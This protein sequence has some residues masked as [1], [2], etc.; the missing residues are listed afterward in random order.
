LFTAPGYCKY[1]FRIVS[2]VALI[3]NQYIC[4]SYLR[5]GRSQFKEK[6]METEEKSDVP[7]RLTGAVD[8]LRSILESLKAGPDPEFARITADRDEVFGHFRPIFSTEHVNQITADEFKDFLS[9]KKNRHWR[10]IHRHQKTI[11]S[12]MDKLRRALSVLVDEKKP[13]IE[14]LNFLVPSME[15]QN[16]VYGLSKAI[17]TPILMV[18]YPEKYGVWNEVSRASMEQLGIWPKLSSQASFG[19]RYVQV[20]E[21]LLQLSQALEIDLW[22]LDWLW[23]K[24]PTAEPRGKD[25]SGNRPVAHLLFKWSPDRDPETIEKHRRV[26]ESRGSVWWGR[27]GNPESSGMSADK[28]ELIRGQLNSGAEIYAFIYSRREAWR[29]M[30]QEITAN[31][32]DVDNDLRPEDFALTRCNLYARVSNFER[33]ADGWVE[34]RLVPAGD[35]SAE[36]MMS[37]LRNQTSPLLVYERADKDEDQNGN[38]VVHPVKLTME[39]LKEQTLWEPDELGELLDALRGA[40]PQVVLAGPPGTGKTWVAQHIARFL[41]DD[42]PEGSKI[43]QLHPTYGYEQFIEGLRPDVDKAGA[44]KFERIDG[45]V[46]KMANDVVTDGL[47][48]VLI[49]DEMNRANLPKVFGELMY[50]FEYRQKPVDLLY[51]KDFRLPEKLLFIGTMN[52][53]D[54]SIRS[55]DIA[56]RRRF[57]VFECPPDVKVLE[58]FYRNH[59]NGVESL[60]Q[61]FEALNDELRS[62]LDRHHT[63]GHTFFM[64]REGMDAAR[65]RRIWRRKI[66]PLIEEYFF[67]EPDVAAEFT[68]G[69]F[70]PEAGGAD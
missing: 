40:S 14:R 1:G 56:L 68:P 24:V 41:T 35:P 7:S 51:S 26:A 47:L 48:R 31:V 30:L 2:V 9:F 6:V 10:H 29:T 12:D 38:G 59:E 5:S 18:V 17:L 13:I 19:E 37:A 65:L 11:T 53:A 39:W 36:G 25:K 15:G 28:L 70:W 3:I 21:I 60:L 44:L 32:A 67:D 57:E 54:R 63:I 34:S 69:R 16:F 62:R 49:V 43:V 42:A 33:L 52:T 20:N 45:V 23:W 58:R 64:S 4:T 55:I 46:L 27:L 61:G 66:G 50:L 8:V 22:T